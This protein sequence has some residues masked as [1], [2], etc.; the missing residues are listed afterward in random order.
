MAQ[1][2]I[3]PTRPACAEDVVNLLR[4]LDEVSWLQVVADAQT[5]NKYRAGEL[6][7]RP[8]LEPDKV[9]RARKISRLCYGLP[10]WLGGTFLARG[11]R[12]KSCY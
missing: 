12:Q 7:A 3:D 4:R 10:W 6:L 8:S 1:T 11:Q 5:W 9:E 2:A